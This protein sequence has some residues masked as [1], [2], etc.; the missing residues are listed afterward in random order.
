MKFKNI[1]IALLIALIFNF[2]RASSYGRFT[3]RY[4]C[5]HTNIYSYSSYKHRHANV[6]V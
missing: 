1:N 6:D 2:V 3:D 5:A 4:G